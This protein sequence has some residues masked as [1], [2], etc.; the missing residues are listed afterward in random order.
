MREEQSPA[1]T[2]IAVI[3]WLCAQQILV[4]KAAAIWALIGVS[5]WTR[6]YHNLVWK[7]FWTTIYVSRR[8]AD[9]RPDALYGE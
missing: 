3:G 6:Q 4:L 1:I 2:R 8:Y 5:D 9:D 7:R